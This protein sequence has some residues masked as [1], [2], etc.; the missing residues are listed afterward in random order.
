MRTVKRIF[1]F[2]ILFIVILLTIDLVLFLKSPVINHSALEPNHNYVSYDIKPNT[3]LIDLLTDL[4]HK[5]I[6]KRPVYLYVLAQITFKA[7]IHVGEY[8]FYDT[9]TPSQFLNQINKGRVVQHRLTIIEGWTFKQ[10]MSLIQRNPYLQHE[11]TGLTP[12]AVMARLGYPGEY[13]EGMFFPDTYFF[14]KGMTDVEFLQRAYLLMQKKLSKEWQNRAANLPYANMYEALIIASMIEEEAMS[15]NERAIIAGVIINRL[16]KQMRL[17]IDPTVMYGLQDQN[18]FNGKLLRSHL[19][20]PSIYNTYTNAGIPPTPIS[21]PGLAS[22]YAALH[23]QHHNYL[24]YVSN[25]NGTHTFSENLEQHN[26]AIKQYRRHQQ[27]EQ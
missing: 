3:D 20:I 11:L 4:S 9:A 8:H 5:N 22:I 12:T 16:K 21:M 10:M 15:A 23:P 18:S 1:V 2:I 17:Q 27:N 25:G 14:P 26:Q 7:H 6:I 19:H 13:P 24:Y